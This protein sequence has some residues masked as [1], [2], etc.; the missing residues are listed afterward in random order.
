MN[1]VLLTRSGKTI[2][3]RLSWTIQ[4]G[5]HWA[6]LGPNGSGKTMTLNIVSAQLWPSDG[7]VAVLGKEFGTYDLRKL[8]R[9]VGIVSFDLQYAFMQR[10]DT[11]LEVVVSG[12]YNS[13]GLFDVEPTNDV[14][15]K[16][17]TLLFLLDCE[18]LADR[19]FRTFSH[20]EQKRVIIARALITDPKL[21]IL[22]EPCTG[23][24]IASREK[25]LVT[26]QDIAARQRDLSTVFVTHH[27]EEILPYVSH[28]F[29][30]KEGQCIC[31][32]PKKSV[33]TK[34]NVRALFDVAVDI[35]ESNGRFWTTIHA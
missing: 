2:L 15:Q 21:L 27:S 26:V 22:D 12:F 35:N 20:G 6:L 24:D 7:K 18:E 30:L 10:A 28:C 13:I 25:F 17:K 16:A 33:M 23:L 5:E 1:D 3:N 29:F 31:Q 34:E 32:G 11:A 14:I 19:P 9:D 8:R 4:P